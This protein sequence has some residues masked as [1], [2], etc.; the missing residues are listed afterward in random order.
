MSQDLYLVQIYYSLS[1][2]KHFK[3]YDFTDVSIKFMIDIF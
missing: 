3:H 1:P 2:T